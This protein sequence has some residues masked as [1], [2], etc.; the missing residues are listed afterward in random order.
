ML[1]SLALGG[2][3]HMG[4]KF[5]P[6]PLGIHIAIKEVDNLFPSNMEGFVITGV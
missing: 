3:G 6:D 4:G 2:G 5:L 1:F